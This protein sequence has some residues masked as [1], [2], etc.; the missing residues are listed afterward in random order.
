MLR[1]L[2]FAVLVALSTSLSAQ[3]IRTA[4]GSYTYHVPSDVPKEQAERIAFDRLRVQILADN[5]GRLVSS[6]NFT[7]VSNTNGD[8]S[9]STL[10]FGESEVKGEW[11]ETVG[12]P[13]YTYIMD[14]QGGLIITIS[15]T[16]KIREITT[17][18]I[19]F[20]AKLLRNA[21]DDVFESYEYKENDRLYMSFH[22][23]VAG[24][25]SVYIFDGESDVY[26]MLPYS[27]QE[28]ESMPIEAN[29][30]YAFFSLRDTS[31]GI[32]T[33]LIDEY[34][35]SCSKRIEYN[36]VYIIFSPNKFIKPVDSFGKNVDDPRV[37]K[38]EDFQKWL[39]KYRKMDPSMCVDIKDISINK[40]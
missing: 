38:F 37:L 29:K 15:A 30:R 5:F 7:N 17:P 18:P 36:R 12:K 25:L 1:F 13:K 10:T 21:T 24:Y 27:N 6:T 11:L 26:R 33:D 39:T 16:G 32:S 9:V 28:V 35:L 23:P 2:L 19:A 20:K 31:T 4:S 8:S 40:N 3:K 14:E 22:S 34:M